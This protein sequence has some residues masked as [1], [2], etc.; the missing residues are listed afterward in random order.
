MKAGRNI[1]KDV[2]GT[3]ASKKHFLKVFAPFPRL[4]FVSEN[5]HTERSETSKIHSVKAMH[6]F[7]LGANKVMSNIALQEGF[8]VFSEA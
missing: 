8:C 5:S 3:A 7:M 1:I 2:F 4:D 6:V